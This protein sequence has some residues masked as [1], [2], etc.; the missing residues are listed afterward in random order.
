MPKKAIDL[1]ALMEKIAAGEV[2]A[3]KPL[4]KICDSVGREF[5]VFQNSGL[6][7]LLGLEGNGKTKF[8]TSCANQFLEFM[9][10]GDPLTILFIIFRLKSKIS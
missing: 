6:N 7:I 8:I 2:V 5:F 1:V 3:D 9:I 10:R 4:F